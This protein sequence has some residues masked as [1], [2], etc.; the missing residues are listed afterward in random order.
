ML[1]N[2]RA[3]VADDVNWMQA[4]MT[5]DEVWELERL[6]LVDEKSGDIWWPDLGPEAGTIGANMTL[7]GKR[8][9]R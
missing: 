2:M 3:L 7:M 5:A 6:G 9:Y 1:A 8:R 4:A